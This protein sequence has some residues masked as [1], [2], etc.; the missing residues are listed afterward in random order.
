[1]FEMCNINICLKAKLAQR[2]QSMMLHQS[3]ITS[4]RGAKNI[5]YITV[6]LHGAV[7]LK[8]SVSIRRHMIINQ[9]VCLS[10][11]AGR[12]WLSSVHCLMY[13]MSGKC[14]SHFP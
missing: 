12:I 3:H 14:L 6:L 11:I 8:T 10:Y 1:M 2:F 5:F 13:K 7:K 4:A 9:S